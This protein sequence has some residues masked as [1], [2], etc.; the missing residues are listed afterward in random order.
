VPLIAKQSGH[1]ASVSAAISAGLAHVTG[2]DPTV[3]GKPSRLVMDAVAARTGLAPHEV[4]VV[5]DDPALEVELGFRCGS[6]TVL[7]LSGIARADDLPRLPLERQP[8]FV[9]EGVHELLALLRRHAR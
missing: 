4:V 2:V 5:G 6:T 9:L 1:V 3:L 7:V 8:D